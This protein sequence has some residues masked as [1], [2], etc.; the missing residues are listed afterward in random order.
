MRKE[1]LITALLELM[2]KEFKKNDSAE[3]IA[4]LAPKVAVN[5]RVGANED[6]SAS[7]KRKHRERDDA[8]RMDREQ[9]SLLLK[10]RKTAKRPLPEPVKLP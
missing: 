8:E 1:D 6:S 9:S 4:D 5:H 10:T 3:G 7:K 2:E